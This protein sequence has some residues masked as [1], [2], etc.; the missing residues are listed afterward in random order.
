MRRQYRRPEIVVY[1][2]V[3]QLTL[4][5]HSNLPD[6]NTNGTVFTPDNCS[7]TDGVGSSGD[8]NPF[9]CGT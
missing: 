4:G 2:R 8:S 5:Q 3:D 1:G 7:T 6:F 9:V